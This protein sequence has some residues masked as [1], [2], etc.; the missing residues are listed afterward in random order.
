[1]LKAGDLLI[2]NDSRVMPARLYG[3]KESGGKLEVFVE[4]I[5]SNDLIRCFIR[6]SK[7]PKVGSKIKVAS[8]NAEIVAFDL[9]LAMYTVKFYDANVYELMQTAGEIPLPPY[10]K[11]DVMPCDYETYQTVYA[12][13]LGSVAAPTAG[14]H[15]TI[16]LLQELIARG[17]QIGYITLHVG[18]GTFAPIRED[19]LD[20]HI[21]HYEHVTVKQDLV[22]LIVNTKKAGN[23]VICVG[24]TSVRAIETAALNGTIVPFNGETNLFI[25][26]GFK[27]KIVDAIITNFHLPGSTLLQLVAAFIGVEKLL[28]VYH[29]AIEHNYRF[30]SYGDAM[31]IDQGELSAV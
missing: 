15:F 21:M 13:E 2:L 31:F 23:K 26:P 24:T 19:D 8:K 1:M 6:S 30:Y 5:I 14:L 20:K 29:H 9:A 25:R 3:H 4:R 28:H 18:A 11:R 22:E 27:F 16:E 17:V 10:L 12:K 7:S